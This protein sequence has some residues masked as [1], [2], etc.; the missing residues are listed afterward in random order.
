[1]SQ[2][3]SIS[4]RKDIPATYRETPIADFLAYHNLHEGFKTYAFAEILIITCMDFRVSLNV[5]DKFAFIIRAAGANTR[6]SEFGVSY[7]I[8][9]AN[10]R[11]IALIGHTDCGMVHLH[12]RKDAY[13]SG[14][15]ELPGWDKAKSTGNFHAFAPLH[16]IGSEYDFTL[17]EAKR[18]Q[19]QYPGVMVAPMI[20]DVK[21]GKIALIPDGQV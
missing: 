7:A 5:P 14:L 6:H 3:L 9:I 10:I 11:H 18:L 16:E 2:L 15:S 8:A 12:D 20:Y 13:A 17:T 4:A 1:M 21:N 19:Q